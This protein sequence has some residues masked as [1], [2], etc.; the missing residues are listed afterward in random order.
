MRRITIVII[1]KIVVAFGKIFLVT[2]Y[3]GSVTLTKRPYIG[4]LGSFVKKDKMAR[5][6]TSHIMKERV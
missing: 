2:L 4:F 6:M 5:P 3:I 1:I